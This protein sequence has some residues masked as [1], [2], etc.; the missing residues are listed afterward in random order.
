MYRQTERKWAGTN[1][2]VPDATGPYGRGDGPGRG[3][4]Q[5]LGLLSRIGMPVRDSQGRLNLVNFSGQ[6]PDPLLKLKI[7]LYLKAHPDIKEGDSIAMD[8]VHSFFE[9]SKTA[10]LERALSYRLLQ[11]KPQ[12]SVHDEKVAGVLDTLARKGPTAIRPMLQKLIVM[13]KYPELHAQIGAAGLASKAVSKNRVGIIKN[14]LKNNKSL[15][16]RVLDAENK[17]YSGKTL[18]DLIM[19]DSSIPNI[20]TMLM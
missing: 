5:G 8:E 19:R 13:F 4:G 16:N 7:L 9:P 17:L 11:A 2:G 6:Q 3:E 15:F 20:N 14:L 10:S 1:R 18:E 12:S